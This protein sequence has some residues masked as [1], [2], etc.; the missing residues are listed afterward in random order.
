MAVLLSG[1]EFRVQE[2][3]RIHWLWVWTPRVS[4]IWTHSSRTQR[5]RS[6]LRHMIGSSDRGSRRM[7]IQALARMSNLAKS[8]KESTFQLT[9]T[10]QKR[11][12]SVSALDP[13]GHSDSRLQAQAPIVHQATSATLT[14]ENSST[15]HTPLWLPSSR[16]CKWMT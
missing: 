9:S 4:I 12:L 10:A 15:T 2:P 11:H 8:A 6:G 14:L 3:T 16:R 5:P 13:D 1:K 7:R